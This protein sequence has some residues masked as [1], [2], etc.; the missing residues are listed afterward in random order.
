MRRRKKLRNRIEGE[1]E[2][3]KKG[4]KRKKEESQQVKILTKGA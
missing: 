4:K 3:K 1:K 2:E